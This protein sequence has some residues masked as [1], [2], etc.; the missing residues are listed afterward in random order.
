MT[1]ICCCRELPE[2]TA[3]RLVEGVVNPLLD[4]PMGRFRV[5][6]LESIVTRRKGYD[7]FKAQHPKGATSIDNSL[8]S[9]ENMMS[10]ALSSTISYLI[11]RYI[12]ASEA[13]SGRRLPT[14]DVCSRSRNEHARTAIVQS[15]IYS[16][17]SQPMARGGIG[18]TYSPEVTEATSGARTM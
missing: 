14:R 8:T 17:I 5:L 7:A 15:L 9:L 11:S 13:A 16:K 1:Y 10:S 6:R 12:R 2:C 18:D 3:R 4:V